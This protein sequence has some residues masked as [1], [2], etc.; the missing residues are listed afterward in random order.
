MRFLMVTLFLVACGGSQA[1]APESPAKDQAEVSCLISWSLDLTFVDD[2]S[3]PIPFIT[4]VDEDDS[5]Q[6][7]QANKEGKVR[8]TGL[9]G[10]QFS[11]WAGPADGNLV[12]CDTIARPDF[13]A[14]AKFQV[15]YEAENQPKGCKKL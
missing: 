15:V 14:N 2:Q 3:R 7:D 4:V 12:Y 11:V 5:G 1:P 8:F 10:Q 9:C 6:G 13:Y